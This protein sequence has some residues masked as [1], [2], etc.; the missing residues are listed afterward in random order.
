[1]QKMSAQLSLT[2][3]AGGTAITAL[4]GYCFYSVLLARKKPTAE[5]KKILQPLTDQES[6]HEANQYYS[7]LISEGQQLLVMLNKLNS[8]TNRDEKKTA[9]EDLAKL[10]M[11]RNQNENYPLIAFAENLQAEVALLKRYFLELTQRVIQ[12]KMQIEGQD[13]NFIFESEELNEK[14]CLL[15]HELQALVYEIKETVRYRH[16]ELLRAITNSKSTF[17]VEQNKPS[18]YYHSNGFLSIPLF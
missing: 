7:G 6:L 8:C 2:E 12:N 9:R 16:E 15:I 4:I 17:N 13:T 11:S 3:I 18:I 1:M 14:M 10:V 5:Q